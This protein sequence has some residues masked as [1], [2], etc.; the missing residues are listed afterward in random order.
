MK[1]HDLFGLLSDPTRTSIISILNSKKDIC[2]TDLSKKADLSLSATS[3]QLK[4]LELL[5]LVEKCRKGQEICYCLNRKSG[6]TKK[7]L[8]LLKTV[9]HD[10]K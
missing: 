5:G 8:N 3:H 1:N 2:V 10:F 4:K 7:I 9:K 6:L